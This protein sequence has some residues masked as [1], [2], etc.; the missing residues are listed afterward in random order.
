MV[1]ADTGHE[2]CKYGFPWPILRETCILEPLKKKTDDDKDKKR[3]YT[4]YFQTLR[5]ELEKI[6]TT[7]KTESYHL[8]E[9][10]SLDT[11]LDDLSLALDI[12]VTIAQLISCILRQLHLCT[13]SWFQNFYFLSDRL[14]FV[15]KKC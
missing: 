5:L 8:K 11:L 2:T 7:F 12:P 13:L 14:P 4:E 6:A 9:I 1:D 15:A 10:V 3:L